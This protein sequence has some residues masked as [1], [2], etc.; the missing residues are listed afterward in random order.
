MCSSD[1]VDGGGGTIH[2]SALWTIRADRI[3]NMVETVHFE[4]R[5]VPLD[6]HS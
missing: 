4:G 2:D 6:N 5:A 1:L 3:A